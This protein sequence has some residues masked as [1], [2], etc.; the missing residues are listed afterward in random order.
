MAA[1]EPDPFTFAT[2]RWRRRRTLC[3]VGRAAPLPSLPAPGEVSRLPLT[4]R[5]G[6]RVGAEGEWPRPR[7]TVGPSPAPPFCS[8]RRWFWLGW[9][10]LL[11]LLSFLL[12]AVPPS[13]TS[14]PSALCVSLAAAAAQPP[15]FLKRRV[16]EKEEGGYEARPCERR[17][18]QPIGTL[19]WPAA[20]PPT[21]SSVDWLGQQR[22]VPTGRRSETRV[23]RA[24][25]DAGGGARGGAAEVNLG[26]AR[27][28]ECPSGFF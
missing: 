14:R 16:E 1:A 23:R 26:R 17:L 21:P 13:L 10:L 22:A 5:A 28:C 18:G 11:L 24:A 4:G 25:R 27:R 6:V 9:A 19:L 20:P 12:P 15:F 3:I 8:R 7:L 2:G